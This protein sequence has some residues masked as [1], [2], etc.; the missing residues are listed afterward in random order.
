MRAISKESTQEIFRS[1][2]LEALDNAASK[3]FGYDQKITGPGATD[4]ELPELFKTL[5][6]HLEKVAARHGCCLVEEPESWDA[7]F[8]FIQ[9]GQFW[10][11]LTKPQGELLIKQGDAYDQ[12]GHCVYFKP[13]GLEKE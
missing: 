3:A 6:V 2:L 12:S 1:H 10:L 8:Y 11:E 4:A 7:E 5:D 9:S 13:M